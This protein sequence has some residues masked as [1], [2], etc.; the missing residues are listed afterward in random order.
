[1]PEIGSGHSV[2]SAP[3]LWDFSKE[4]SSYKIEIKMNGT[5]SI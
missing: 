2:I 1:M 5:C 3:I 4:T